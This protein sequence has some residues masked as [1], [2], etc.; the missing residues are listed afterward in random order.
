MPFPLKLQYPKTGD[1]SLDTMW[2]QWRWAI[3][4]AFNIIP[5][6]HVRVSR[7][8]LGNKI[9]V[10]I[11]TN[12]ELAKVTTAATAAGLSQAYTTT[13]VATVLV[14]SGTSPLVVP[15]VPFSIGFRNYHDKTYAVGATV[16]LF[17]HARGWWYVMDV[18]S[19]THLS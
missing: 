15:P 9:S 18:D 16:A 12:F 13:G 1:A 6:A 8:A 11:P 19:C 3:Q 7:E 17:R 14:D 4:Y 10:N 2:K 5:G